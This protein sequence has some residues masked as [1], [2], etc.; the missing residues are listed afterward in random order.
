MFTEEIE[1]ILYDA[2]DDYSVLDGDYALI[3]DDCS[4]YDNDDCIYDD[5][6]LLYGENEGLTQ[7]E[8]EESLLED[9]LYQ[10][11]Q[12]AFYSLLG[13]DWKSQTELID[14]FFSLIY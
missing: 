2:A 3:D 10:S 4:V 8:I 12:Q 7:K 13:W 9:I 14:Y 1:Y 6:Y 5:D 11:I